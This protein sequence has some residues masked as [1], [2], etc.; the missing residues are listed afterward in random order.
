MAREKRT[1]PCSNCKR[2]KVKC[3]YL[4]SLPC[5]RCVNSGLTSTCHFVA[6]LPSFK[7][8]LLDAPPVQSAYSSPTLLSANFIPQK[9][10]T[11]VNQNQVVYYPQANPT[12][13]TPKPLTNHQVPLPTQPKS[14]LMNFPPPNPASQSRFSN[15]T[16]SHQ[17]SDLPHL[18]HTNHT[19][20]DKSQQVEEAALPAKLSPPFLAQIPSEILPKD[21]EWKTAMENKLNSFDSKFDNLLDVLK[22]NQ[23]SLSNER[24]LKNRYAAQNEQFRRYHQEFLSSR[25]HSPSLLNDLNESFSLKRPYTGTDSP[26]EVKRSKYPTNDFRDHVISLEEAK[27][28][29]S[30]FETNIAQQLFGFDVKQFSVDVIWDNSPILI[31][32]ICT[33]ASMHYPDPLIS[34][35]GQTLQMNLHDLCAKLLFKGKPQ[36]ELEGFNT[37]MALVLCSFWLSDSQRFTGLALQLAKEF[38]FNKRRPSR[39]QSTLSEVDRLKLWY[40]LY[41]LDGQQSMTLNRQNL[42][43]G[44]DQTFKSS[45]QLLLSDASEAD[46]KSPLSI[47]CSEPND[48]DVTLKTNGTNGKTKT[49][50]PSRFTDLRLVSQVEYNQALNEAFKGNAWELIAPNSFG[51]PS[52]SNLE[53]DKWMVSWTVLLAPMNNG[54][55]WLS[56]STLIYYNFAK[57]HINSSIVRRL[58]T[59]TGDGD[60]VFP[61]WENYEQAKVGH[62]QTSIAEVGE[63]ESDVEDDE[64]DD[65]ISNKELVSQDETLLGLNIAVNAAQTVLNLVLNDKD[66]L[67]ELKYVPVHIHIMLYYAALLL[68]NPP[69]SF[70]GEPRLESY[71]EKLIENLKMVRLLQKRVDM[72]FPTD[73]NF[74]DRFIKSLDTVI[75]E[76]TSRLKQELSESEVPVSS[77]AGLLNELSTFQYTDGKLTLVPDI[78]EDSRESSP[79]SERIS[80]W[81]G[82]HHGHP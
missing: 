18:K 46:G 5:A 67:S 43:D 2:S 42:L 11:S 30:F 73:R 57:I 25:S 52:K 79:R 59:D 7:L 71:F 1:K 53:L 80:A 74:G 72:N 41:I 63:E 31:C 16:N 45:R 26:P 82:S 70:S 37:I 40:L 48:K 27:E 68:V 38:E 69:V 66:I 29:F 56:K 22:E 4:E 60:V 33:I 14:Q 64:E 75:Q 21:Q 35:K 24:E 10:G 23:K 8:P 62:Q 77:K 54:S 34:S 20:A 55:V 6:K 49:M 61:R 78:A 58:Q 12:Q 44:N 51:I 19:F 65:F 39:S 50:S 47:N 15:H 3:E 32:A 36:T 13:P 28:L 76:T 17:V 81:P 9:N